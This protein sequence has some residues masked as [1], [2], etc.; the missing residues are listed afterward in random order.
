MV[1]DSQQSNID[2]QL[3]L[4]AGGTRGWRQNFHPSTNGVRADQQSM[5]ANDNDE[6]AIVVVVSLD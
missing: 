1:S 5:S 2:G 3:Q 6:D 4:K